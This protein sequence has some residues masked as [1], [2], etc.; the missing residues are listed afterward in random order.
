MGTADTDDII[1]TDLCALF[2]QTFSSLSEA[3]VQKVLVFEIYKPGDDFNDIVW[4]KIMWLCNFQT[5]FLK[6]TELCIFVV[7]VVSVVDFF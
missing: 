1:H 3:I 4:H 2:I 7:V 6:N 5:Y